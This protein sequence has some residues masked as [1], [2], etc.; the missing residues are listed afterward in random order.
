MPWQMLPKNKLEDLLIDLFVGLIRIDR[1]PNDP[2]HFLYKMLVARL[3]LKGFQ[4]KA[5]CQLFALSENT[6]RHWAAVLLNG[7]AEKVAEV[8]G[9]LPKGK[10]TREVRAFVEYR[11]FELTLSGSHDYRKRILKELLD[12]FELSVSGETL[13]VFFRDLDKQQETASTDADKEVSLEQKTELVTPAIE[14]ENTMAK[15]DKSTDDDGLVKLNKPEEISLEQEKD[16]IVHKSIQGDIEELEEALL[17]GFIAEEKTE[18]LASPSAIVTSS[19]DV[20]AVRETQSPCAIYTGNVDKPRRLAE[21]S[22]PVSKVA[23][24]PLSNRR[25]L[26]N[27]MQIHHLGLIFFL[28]FLD[29]LRQGLSKGKEVC[30]QLV[31]QV[32]Q[33]AINIEQNKILCLE[34]MS[35]LIGRCRTDQKNLRKKLTALSSFGFIQELLQFNLK[36]TGNETSKNFFYDPHG[37]DYTG[38]SPLLKGWCGRL[39]TTTKMLYSDYIHSE[40]GEPLFMKHFDNFYDLR[41]RIVF[42][43][44]EFQQAFTSS[45]RNEMCFVVDRGIY[46]IEAMLGML[47]HGFHLI[48]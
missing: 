31:S 2:Q 15:I 1:V 41:E 25:V 39:K 8:F 22:S 26:H 4:L 17:P 19:E 28:P 32:L 10:L 46:G 36:M 37:K 23:L 20:D 11:Y 27:K 14:L 42:T 34:S 16:T 30:L 29:Q 18:E 12:I 43:L 5:L 38:G 35:F 44:K 13:R 48:T 7:S 6:V 24:L 21:F 40:N 45:M 33:G 9:I 47:D 3:R